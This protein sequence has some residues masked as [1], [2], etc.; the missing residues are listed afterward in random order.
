[1]NEQ[2]E[3][4]DKEFLFS[5]L[6]EIIDRIERCGASTQLTHAVSLTADLRQAIG[7][8]WNPGNSYA[9]ERVKKQL[10]EKRQLPEG[11]Y[12]GG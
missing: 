7:N 5:A 1:M 4:L 9:L 11:G 3:A 8:K 12:E 2:N 6:C 10:P